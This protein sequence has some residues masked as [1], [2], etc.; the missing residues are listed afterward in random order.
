MMN[1]QLKI[2]EEGRV[3]KVKFTSYTHEGLGVGKIEGQNNK[4]EELINFPVFVFGAIVGETALVQITKMMK[5]FAYG[6]IYKT[7]EETISPNRIIP[8]CP[9]YEECGG[10]NIMHMN[11]QEQL[12]F[13]TQM[14]K[15]TLERLGDIKDIDIKNVIGCKNNLYYR[16]KVQ[17]P[18]NRENNKTKIGFYRRDSHIICPLSKCFIQS[19]LSTN[20]TIHAKNVAVELGVI[21]YNEN[22]KDGILKHI[23]IR[24]NHDESELMVVLVVK[25]DSFI[26]DNFNK[27]LSNKIIKKFPNVKSIIVNLNPKDSN[28][29]L[30][31]KNITIYGKPYIEDILCDFK[32]RIGATSFYQVNHDQCEVLYKTALANA[33]LTKEDILIDAYCG[34]GTIGMIASKY[35][36]EVYSVEIVEEA[37]K[38][39]KDNAKLNKIDNIHFSCNPAEKQII[40][41]IDEGL[42]PTAMVVDPPRKGC[43]KILLDMIAAANIKKVIYISCDP[44]S[45]ARD[46]KIL[47]SY[48]YQINFVQGV[49]M[50][51]QTSHC[52][53]V[54]CLERK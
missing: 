15:D 48:N 23:I 10:C 44:A 18:V 6:M 17:V 9:S 28:T 13:K 16:N 49:D 22:T 29:I 53:T 41:W 5:T 8:I 37:I 14:L 12:A 52:E 4:G 24:K 36:K 7:Y 21:G 54:V 30:G 42:K 27:L 40:K 39:A 25:D 47:M 2:I 19:E 45:L 43:D 38:N 34:I 51:P 50:F 46:L 20:L 11:Y 26:N 33:N 3:T 35:V 1:N 32:F 31:N